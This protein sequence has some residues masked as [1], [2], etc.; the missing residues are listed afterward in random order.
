MASGVAAAGATAVVGPSGAR[1]EASAIHDPALRK[2]IEDAIHKGRIVAFLTG[3]PE[4]PHCG[5]TVRI[6]EL[7]EQLNVNFEHFDVLS[8]DEVC[9][10]LKAYSDWPTYPQL[11]VDG[12]LIGGYDVVKGMMLDGSLVKLLKEKKLL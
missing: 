1:A 2:R 11:Y 6:V 3:T 7:L 4:D 9:E 5:F 8:D 10:G 12:D